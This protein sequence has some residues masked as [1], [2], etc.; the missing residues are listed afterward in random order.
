MPRDPASPKSFSPHLIRVSL[1]GREETRAA[2]KS[3]LSALSP[4]GPFGSG[5]IP[6]GSCQCAF[7]GTGCFL[8]LCAVRPPHGGAAS[9]SPVE[10]H[11][12]RPDVDAARSGFLRVR[13]SA[14]CRSV[15]Q[16]ISSRLSLEVSSCVY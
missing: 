12:T 10:R 2:E 14:V 13:C 11:G 8:F 5:A 1:A 6:P 3:G 4:R 16:A 15:V 9:T 7:A